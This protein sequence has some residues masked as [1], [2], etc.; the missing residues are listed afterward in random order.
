[1]NRHGYS[2]YV[3]IKGFKMK[4]ETIQSEIVYTGRAFNVRVD[5]VRLPNGR[6]IHL[7]IVNHSPAVV[8][9]PLDNLARIWFVR[10]YRH[11]TGDSLLELPAGT[12]EANE[13]PLKCAAR[14]LREEIGMSAERLTQI[15]EFFIAPGYSTEYLYIYLATGLKSNP[16][17]AD[18]DELIQVE[19]ISVDQAYKMV[20]DG[21]LRDAKTLAT[22]LLASNLLNNLLPPSFDDYSR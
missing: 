15:G 7:D 10:Q 8:I 22:L 13:P 6:V 12:L 4:I 2:Q 18:E 5:K 21:Q 16:L 19:K 9:L 1:M 11:A 20:Q 3:F 17:P 14:E